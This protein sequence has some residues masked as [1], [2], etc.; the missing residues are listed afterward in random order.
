MQTINWLPVTE[1]FQ[2]GIVTHIFKQKH[3][4]APKFRDEMFASADQ[5]QTKTRASTNKLFQPQCNK[6]IGYRAISSLGPTL[7]NKL[8]NQLKSVNSVNTFKHKIK[9]HFFREYQKKEDNI[10]VYY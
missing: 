5:Y 9:E 8:P 7:W 3:T 2:Q 1:R 4:L 6:V 10:Y